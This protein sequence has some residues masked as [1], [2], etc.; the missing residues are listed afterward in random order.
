MLIRAAGLGDIRK[1]G[2]F[3]LE[4]WRE[5]GPAAPGFSGAT[6]E[7]MRELASE[8]SLRA[9]LTDPA[10][11]IF[12]AEDAGRVLGFASLK[13]LDSFTAELSGIA[14]LQ[15]MVGRGVGT[16]LLKAARESGAIAGYRKVVVKTEVSNERAISFYKKQGFVEI[17]KTT[18][19]VEGTKVNLMVLERCLQ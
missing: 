19:D 18:E 6:E 13:K 8:R 2:D 4:A 7:A 5:A 9:K 10:L 14:V 12:V 16:A 1:L 11:R 15:G 3:L 17:A